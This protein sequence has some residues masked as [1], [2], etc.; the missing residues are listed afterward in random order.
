M[1]SFEYPTAIRCPAC[2]ETLSTGGLAPESAPIPWHGSGD[3]VCP[4]S[5][6]TL[7]EI[8]VPESER[9]AFLA[10]WVREGPGRRGPERVDPSEVVRG[11]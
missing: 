7:A 1:S 4:G 5:D 3:G 2:F 10:G 6:K 8:G 11:G 9:A